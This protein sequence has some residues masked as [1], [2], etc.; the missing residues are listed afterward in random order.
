[1]DSKSSE[2]FLNIHATA[3]VQ[4]SSSYSSEVVIFQNY[5][6]EILLQDKRSGS[7]F[8]CLG[9]YPDHLLEGSTLSLDV[10]NFTPAY[11]FRRLAKELNDYDL[12]WDITR[13]IFP[14]SQRRDLPQDKPLFITVLVESTRK[15]FIE[16]VFVNGLIEEA[17]TLALSAAILENGIWVS[18]SAAAAT[19]MRTVIVRFADA[20]AA[21]A[22]YYIA[23]TDFI[24][25]SRRTR[26]SDAAS[27]AVSCVNETNKS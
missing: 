24:G 4:S 15:F 13:R 20:D 16:N 18:A 12:S 26:R 10:D 19:S 27:D 5:H 9:S 14:E 17:M 22:A 2:R 7:V 3:R 1:M 25:V 23:T 21:A 6:E 8:E 11:I